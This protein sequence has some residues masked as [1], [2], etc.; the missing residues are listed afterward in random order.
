M[1]GEAQRDMAAKVRIGFVGVGRMGQ[2][3][4]LR[5]YC[6][7]PECEVVALAELRERTGRKV[8]QRYGV[9]RVYRE[10]QEMLEEE[11]LDGLVASQPFDRHGILLPELLKAGVP[12]FIEKPLASTVPSG[13]AIVRA[14]EQSGT[15]IMVGYNKRSDP[16]CNYAKEQ[17]EAFQQSGELG[18]LKY[19]RVTMPPGDWIANG[20]SDLIDEGDPYPDLPREAPPADMGEETFRAFKAFVNYYIHQVNLIRYFLGEPY[21]VTYAD[22]SGVLLAGVSAS[23]VSCVLEMA[24]YST[25]VDWQESALVA[26]EHGYVK[27]DLPAPLA[28]NR[29][30]RVEILQDPGGRTPVVTRPH[31][32][33]VHAMRQQA[34]NFIAAIRGDRP[35]TCDAA[36]ALE[37]LHV[38]RDAIRLGKGT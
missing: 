33:W 2:C 3:A 15:W 10:A 9:P 5:N 35:P 30:G 25:T 7:L 31:L 38:A 24:P 29:P 12:I 32:P 11:H 17:I 18:R 14:V 36:E 22:A 34:I 23:G 6:V 4:H 16:A 20:F 27:V 19:V 28:V 26:F 1:A 37:D 13:E 21:H 8:A